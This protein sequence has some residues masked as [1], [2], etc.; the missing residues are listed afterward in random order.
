[1]KRLA[2]K[3]LFTENFKYHTIRDTSFYD[4]KMRITSNY[5]ATV[6]KEM[7]ILFRYH[8]KLRTHGPQFYGYYFHYSIR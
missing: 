4:H 3:Q 2:S 6:S 5:H 7:K 8:Y 1:M